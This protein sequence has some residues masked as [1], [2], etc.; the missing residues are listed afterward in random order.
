METLTACIVVN[1]V[2]ELIR[3]RVGGAW[4]SKLP[5]NTLS[6]S[7]NSVH[8]P[9]HT[10]F[11]TLRSSFRTPRLT[12]ELENSSALE[13]L[14]CDLPCSVARGGENMNL[15]LPWSSYLQIYVFVCA[16]NQTAQW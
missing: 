13:S 14:C 12:F 4:V 9:K 6:G 3:K 15:S 11:P 7:R 16:L 2:V 8:I 1:S 10:S 5:R